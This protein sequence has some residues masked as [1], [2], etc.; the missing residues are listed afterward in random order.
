M[1]ETPQLT[2]EVLVTVGERVARQSSRSKESLLNGVVI[3]FVDPD[4]CQV[5]AILE[6]ASPAPMPGG[7]SILTPRRLGQAP[8][9][10]YCGLAITD[11]G[12]GPQRP[13]SCQTI[14]SR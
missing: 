4:L 7:S 10:H 2:I 5:E 6:R 13:N 11:A 8:P 12:V 1:K 3:A 14:C 9:H